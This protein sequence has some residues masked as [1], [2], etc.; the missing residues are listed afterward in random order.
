MLSKLLPLIC[1]AV[2][3]SAAVVT[4]VVPPALRG[5]PSST[6]NTLSLDG[7]DTDAD[8]IANTVAQVNQKTGATDNTPPNQPVPPTVV[9]AIDGTV[10]EAGQLNSTSDASSSRRD[11][12]FFA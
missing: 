1:V 4:T 8:T 6:A 9:T 2:A 10:T 5:P 12:V 7:T 3:A 11:L